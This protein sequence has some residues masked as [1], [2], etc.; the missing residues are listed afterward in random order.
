MAQREL[1]RDLVGEWEFPPRDSGFGASR[2]IWD[3]TII[4]Y[5][6][7]NKQFD[8]RSLEDF[9]GIGVASVKSHSS[10]VWQMVNIHY[11]LVK[12]EYGHLVCAQ[13][14]LMPNTK[15]Y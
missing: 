8:T 1:N 7:V 6:G 11:R 3:G 12:C 13:G 5:L 9:G 4:F 10:C 2:V 15:A 14:K